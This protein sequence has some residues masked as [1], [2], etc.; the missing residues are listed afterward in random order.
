M[1]S[2][3]SRRVAERRSFCE[4]A[5]ASWPLVSRR[6]S[7]SDA[8]PLRGV[9]EPAAEDDDLFLEALQLGL[10]LADLALVLG[11]PSLVLGR[12]ATSSSS[13]VSPGLAP[14]H[15][16]GAPA[17]TLA[18]FSRRTISPA[19]A[20]E[21][22]RASS[23]LAFAA[24]HRP[25]TDIPRH[26]GE[27]PM[28]VWI[29]Q[30]LCTGDGLC[31]EIAPDV[32]TLLDDGLAYVKEGDKVFS[33]PGGAEGLADVPGRAWKRPSSSPPRSAP[34]SASS[35][36]STD[37]RGPSGL[38]PDV[39]PD[40]SVRRDEQPRGRQEPGVR[41]HPVVGT[42]RLAVDVPRAVQHLE[43]LRPSRTPT[44]SSSSRSCATWP[45]VGRYA[46]RMPPGRSACAACFT[47]RHGSGRSSSTRSRSV[48]VDALRRCRAPRPG[49]GA[50]VP[51]KPSTLRCA[52]VGEVGAQLV[53]DDR[54][55]RSD[56]PQQRHRE[57]ARSR[58]PTRARAHRGTRRRAS[59]SARG[60]SGR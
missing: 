7:S 27:S 10:E 52:R 19:S 5:W 21:M 13:R 50:S 12:H 49:A 28:K 11:E 47:T 33:D 31:E 22:H 53:A 48:L 15:Y 45:I 44:T 40:S 57:R 26:R 9:L 37:R 39:E 3:A 14:G 41:H 16:T 32:F 4:T 54:P 23:T 56:R 24:A 29:D 55:G 35:S 17:H 51:S 20:W 43:R 18:S 6:R 2:R 1:C 8:D 34:A 30:D 42:H 25:R 36:R 60:P 46:S 38:R 58:R 59:G